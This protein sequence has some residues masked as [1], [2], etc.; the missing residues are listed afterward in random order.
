MRSGWRTIRVGLDQ[1]VS[2][3]DRGVG[4]NHPRGIVRNIL[5]EKGSGYV[6]REG[7]TRLGVNQA[8]SKV[9]QG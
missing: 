1:A 5:G 3:A 2:K 8:V 6:E 9:D 7:T 4:W